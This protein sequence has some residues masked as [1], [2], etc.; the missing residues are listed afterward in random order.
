MQTYTT[1]QQNRTNKQTKHNIKT[2]HIT[3][4]SENSN[5]KNTFRNIQQHKRNKAN[6]ETHNFCCFFVLFCFLIL[7]PEHFRLLC[8][9]STTLTAEYINI[10]CEARNPNQTSFACD[11]ILPGLLCSFVAET[12]RGFSVRHQKHF[13]AKQ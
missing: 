6:L 13:R 5:N 10:Y 1:Q 12:L 7:N 9:Y 2:K 8:S 3:T 4:N 11:N